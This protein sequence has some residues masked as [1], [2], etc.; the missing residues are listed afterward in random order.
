LTYRSGEPTGVEVNGVGEVEFGPNATEWQLYVLKQDADGRAKIAFSQST[1][2]V[3]SGDSA[4]VNISGLQEEGYFDITEAGRL[5]ESA[6]ITPLANPAIVLP[7][8][9]SSEE[10]ATN[11]WASELQVDHTQR[12]FHGL[13]MDNMNGADVVRFD[14]TCTT[15]IDAAY[16]ASRRRIY[17]LDPERGIVVQVDSEVQRT[18]PSPQAIPEVIQLVDDKVLDANE[19]RKLTHSAQV[20]FAARSEYQHLIDSALWDIGECAR[21]LLEAKVVLMEAALRMSHPTVGRWRE[22]KMAILNQ[23]CD[24]LILIADSQRAALAIDRHASPWEAVDLD[25]RQIRSQELRGRVTVLC[26]WNRGYS[27]AVRTLAAL[28]SLVKSVGGQSVMFLGVCGDQDEQ[29]ARFVGRALEL[30]FPTVMN[31]TENMNLA[32]AF[33]VEGWPSLVVIDRE[34]VVRRNRAGY[35]QAMPAMLLAEL[36][37]LES[38]ARYVSC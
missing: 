11:G 18:W 3:A 2:Q 4:S 21:R 36:E 30:G 9:P 37:R 14:E 8:L 27:W 24:N 22:R 35:W 10:L 25:G 19:L 5:S 31:C 23:E 15:D 26:F 13:M 32:T 16:L 28:N 1:G 33:G 29:E 12:Q 6:T 34:G 38:G 17:R 7:E 20:Y